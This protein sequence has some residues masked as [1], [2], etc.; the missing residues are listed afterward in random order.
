MFRPCNTKAIHVRNCEKRRRVCLRKPQR[1]RAFKTARLQATRL[2][3]ALRLLFSGR[4]LSLSTVMGPAAQIASLK[5]QMD[6]IEQE[7]IRKKC[8][9]E[10]RKS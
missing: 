5:G 2:R 4:P 3:R 1:F 10:F 9:I 7:S 6:A 8:G